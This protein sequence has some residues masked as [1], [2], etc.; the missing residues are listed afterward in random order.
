MAF[1]VVEILNQRQLIKYAYISEK[2]PFLEG[3]PL[4]WR[5]YD[6]LTYFFAMIIYSPNPTFV[7]SLSEIGDLSCITSC[8]VLP[9]FLMD[10]LLTSKSCAISR[11]PPGPRPVK[12]FK[13]IQVWGE[14]VPTCFL[15]YE[16]VITRTYRLTIQ[17]HLCTV[18]KLGIYIYIY[19]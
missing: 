18:F 19:N 13:Q 11:N 10:T 16:D 9:G 3:V 12:T 6:L 14:L 4:T 5:E 7:P 17:N 2:W 15:L 8:L 1:L